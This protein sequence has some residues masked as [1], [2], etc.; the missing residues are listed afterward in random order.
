VKQDEDSQLFQ[1][2]KKSDKS[3]F[4]CLFR[5]YYPMLC[6]YAFKFIDSSDIAEDLVQEVF[7][8]IWT[9]RNT[10]NIT[11]SVVHYLFTSV[12]YRAFAYIR[13]QGTRKEYEQEY[14]DKE[15]QD[16]DEETLPL[17]DY[18]IACLVSDAV[19][20]LPEKCREIFL[21]SREDGLTYSEIADHMSISPKT[22]ENQMSIAFKKLKLILE[23][24]LRQQGI[25]LMLAL[26]YWLLLID[27]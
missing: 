21:L 7:V 2:I 25:G 4:D 24:I 8:S 13:S 6:H 16:K 19:K 9:H 10:I 1:R 11:K 3:A 12:K 26:I 15:A 18:E 20:Q 14:I 5:K 22:V 23:P 17:T 27:Y